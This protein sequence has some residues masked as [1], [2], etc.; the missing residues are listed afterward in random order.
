VDV[1][2]KSTRFLVSG[3]G[4]IYS[5]YPSGNSNHP[6]IDCAKDLENS[7]TAF[8]CYESLMQ[9]AKNDPWHHSAQRIDAKYFLNQDGVIFTVFKN[10]DTNFVGNLEIRVYDA[11]TR[12]DEA[13]QLGED[14]G[15][16]ERLVIDEHPLWRSLLELADAIEGQMIA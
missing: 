10:G 14:E 4:V 7:A 1:K 12:S 2:N 11:P 15:N 9:I 3:T 5:I 8:D 16:G 6:Q 13:W